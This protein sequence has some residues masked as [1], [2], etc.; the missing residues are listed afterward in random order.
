MLIRGHRAAAAPIVKSFDGFV[1]TEGLDNAVALPSGFLGYLNKHGNPVFRAPKPGG[2]KYPLSGGGFIKRMTSRTYLLGLSDGSEILQDYPSS[3][4]SVR[5]T[6]SV[7]YGGDLQTFHDPDLAP[8]EFSPL[9]LYSPGPSTGFELVDTYYGRLGVRPILTDP[10]PMPTPPI[11]V[12]PPQYDVPG[13]PTAP[14]VETLPPAPAP[15]PATSG[16]SGGG[17]SAQANEWYF[18]PAYGD[19]SGGVGNQV[20]DVTDSRLSPWPILA[21]LALVL[22]MGGKRKG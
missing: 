22:I 4:G 14:P 9:F 20:V 5:T 15:A 10:G 19:T 6:G 21:V 2:I 8:A 3:L 13:V 7:F 18:D 16:G 12:D 1:L 11:D 17:S